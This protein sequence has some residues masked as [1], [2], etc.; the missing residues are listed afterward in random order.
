MSKD[1]EN[2]AGDI[3]DLTKING[4]GGISI[5]ADSAKTEYKSTY[6]IIKE[7][8]EIYDELTDKQQAK[9]SA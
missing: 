9:F 8:S 2:I 5:F 7:I 6:Q 3:A 4:K 1:L